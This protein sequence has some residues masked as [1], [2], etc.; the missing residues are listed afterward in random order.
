MNACFFT[1]GVTVN[2]CLTHSRRATPWLAALLLAFGV[3]LPLPA[4]AHEGEDHSASQPVTVSA[5]GETLVAASS[6]GALFEAVL[7]YR[8]FVQG[9]SVDVTLYLV[10]VETNRPMAGATVSASLSEGDRSTNIAFA[11]QP[12][13]PVGAYSATLT[14]ATAAP[15]SWLFD[16]TAGGDSDLIGVT[17]FRASPLQAD[18]A[19]NQKTTP[20]REGTA[21]LPL[22]ALLPVGALLLVA[23]FAAGRATARKG[24]SA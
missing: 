14:P 13:G 5:P 21:P 9:Q 23:A 16:V 1:H 6:S 11:P 17:G 2:R 15:M 10:S 20:H 8:P 18:P 4:P 22:T 3:A 12:G 19:L 7:K 24:V